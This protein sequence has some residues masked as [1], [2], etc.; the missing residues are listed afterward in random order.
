M[1][2]LVQ[3]PSLS[4]WH[5]AR[6]DSPPMVSMLVLALVALGCGGTT[7]PYGDTDA[8]TDGSVDGMS[9]T[10]GDG[11]PDSPSDV[12]P[13]I[14]PDPSADG[15]PDAIPD[16]TPDIGP[17]S[18]WDIYPDYDTDIP[19]DSLPGGA[20]GDRCSSDY[21]C[22][23]VPSSGRMCLTDLFGYITFPGG[24]CSGSCTTDAECGPLGDCVSF[25]GGG[26]YC[27]RNCSSPTDCRTVEG[28]SCSSLP[29]GMGGP[30]CLPPFDS[31][32]APSDY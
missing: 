28:Y 25:Y 12:P 31:S 30:Y 8:A 4:E 27:L 22:M 18:P 7:S 21:S 16:P 10:P 24:Y 14:I 26:S 17:D 3:P 15:I 19:P 29:G 6:N 9:D 13:D 1:Y 32:D 2:P 23:G 11:M 20:V 5:M